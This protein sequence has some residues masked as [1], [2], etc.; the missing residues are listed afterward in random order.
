MLHP[1]DLHFSARLEPM[2]KD[3]QIATELAIAD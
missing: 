2:V 1:K 3:L